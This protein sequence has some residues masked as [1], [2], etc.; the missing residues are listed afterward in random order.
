MLKL[1]ETG[2]VKGKKRMWVAT[3]NPEFVMQAVGDVDF[4]RMLQNGTSLNVVDGIGLVWAQKVLGSNFQFSIFNFQI[5]G[6]LLKGLR[7]GVK[8]ILGKHRNKVVAGSELAADFCRMAKERDYR[9]FFLGGFGDRA[10]RTAEFFEG[11][12]KGLKVDWSPGRPEV[13]N[14]EVMAKI[15]QCK[16]QFLLVAYGMKKQEEWIDQNLAKLDVGLAMG[17]G[18]SFDYY[19]GD[20]KR[21]PKLWCDMGLEWLYSL[22]REPKRW[23]RQLALVRFV[24]KVMKRD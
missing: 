23:R 12:Y 18:R 3:V 10:R 2:L 6:R 19:S 4:K 17:V 11:R 22:L 9:V 20:L 16:P 5:S 8:V 7:E 24:G 15:N 1:V 13:K 21:A 14:E